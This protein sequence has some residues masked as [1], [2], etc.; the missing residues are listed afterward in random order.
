MIARTHMKRSYWDDMER[1]AESFFTRA[2]V[3]WRR[4]APL[5]PPH[6]GKSE[7]RLRL[8]WECCLTLYRA[9]VQSTDDIVVVAGAGGCWHV[10]APYDRVAMHCEVECEWVR[11]YNCQGEALPVP[12]PARPWALQYPRTFALRDLKA[13]QRASTVSPRA[14]P[15]AA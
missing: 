13:V 12:L 8:E 6:Q 7:A 14:R 4:R 3:S 1:D 2:H 10:P 11:G 15:C 9:H 5:P